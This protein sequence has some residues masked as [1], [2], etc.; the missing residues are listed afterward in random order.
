MGHDFVGD[1]L[2]NIIEIFSAIKVAILFDYSEQFD[3]DIEE[4]MEKFVIFAD[5]CLKNTHR[6]V[7]NVFG[8]QEH[9]HHSTQQENKRFGSCFCNAGSLINHSCEPNT[10]WFIYGHK[11]VY[12]S[13]KDINTGEE[14]I[15]SYGPSAD[16]MPF[17]Q[18]QTILKTNY[19]FDCNCEACLRECKTVLC[20]RC[21]HCDG[22][23]GLRL[24]KR[25]N[26]KR[27]PLSSMRSEV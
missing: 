18:R 17:L 4:D 14:V 23:C 15:I 8:W 16:T 2:K 20:I 12:E 19:C 11:L 25:F 5:I 22:P 9:Y 24:I 13:R 1:T 6:I 26:Q 7:T 10:K 27:R 3:F 21:S